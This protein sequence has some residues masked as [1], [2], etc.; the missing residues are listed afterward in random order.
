VEYVQIQFAIDD[1]ARADDIVES[2][3]DRHLVACGQRVGPMVSRYW[4]KGSLE[5]SEEW[6]VLVKTR[7]DLASPVIEAIVDRHPYETPEVLCIP[8]TQGAAAYFAWIDAV[9]VASWE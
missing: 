7:A 5:R 6:L 9:T 1:R 8:I 3:L 2:L 4:W